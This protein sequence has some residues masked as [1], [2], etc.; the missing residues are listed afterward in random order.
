M[1]SFDLSNKFILVRRHEQMQFVVLYVMSEMFQVMSIVLAGLGRL[2]LFYR[3][4]H[5]NH[6]Q[7]IFPRQT[8]GFQ[9]MDDN[10][11][12]YPQTSTDHEFIESS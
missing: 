1:V 3:I 6:H 12:L 8:A 4:V 2:E 5:I 11:R 10:N 9:S 7:W